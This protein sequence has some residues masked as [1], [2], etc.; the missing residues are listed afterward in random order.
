[1]TRR[2]CH[3]SYIATLEIRKVGH[4][5]VDGLWSP[6]TSCQLYWPHVTWRSSEFLLWIIKTSWIK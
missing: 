5:Q 2:W 6:R 4:C 3:Q 1:E